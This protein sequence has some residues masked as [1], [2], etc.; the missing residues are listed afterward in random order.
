MTATTMVV[1]R[2]G[3]TTCPKCHRLGYGPGWSDEHSRPDP[4]CALCGYRAPNPEAE[5][6]MREVNEPIQPGKK[7][8]R[9]PSHG[10]S[11]L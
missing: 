2:A 6:L 8:W 10:G 1:R 11:R 3:L 9:R 5:A 7:R 4:H